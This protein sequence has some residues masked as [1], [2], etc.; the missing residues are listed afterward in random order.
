MAE[1][2]DIP[3]AATAGVAIPESEKVKPSYCWSLNAFPVL[4]EGRFWAIHR[5][6]V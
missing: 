1:L 6:A 4:G 3:A 2:P 5:L